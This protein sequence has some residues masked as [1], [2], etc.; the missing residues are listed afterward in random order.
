MPGYLI[1]ISP[2][3]GWYQ[4]ALDIHLTGPGKQLPKAEVT[5][6]AVVS[7]DDLTQL[8]VR[9]DAQRA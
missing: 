3:V 6:S 5:P 4:V 8:A 1:E 9:R 7:N 2:F